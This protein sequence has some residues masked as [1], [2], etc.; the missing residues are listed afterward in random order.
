MRQRRT[1]ADRA[2]EAGMV[3]LV[4]TLF[5]IGRAIGP[6]ASSEIGGWWARRIGRLLPQHRIALANA[7][8]AFPDKSGDEIAA[9][10]GGAWENSPDTPMGGIAWD[11]NALADPFGHIRNYAEQGVGIIP[12]EES[13]VGKNKPAFGPLAQRE[14]FAHSCTNGSP[15]TLPC[16]F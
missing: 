3:G 11:Q 8:A 12:I 13:Y 4:R 10:V 5:A 2:A 9:I 7:R 6:E 16:L 15:L 14:G 1:V